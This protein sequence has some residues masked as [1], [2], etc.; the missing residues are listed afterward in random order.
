MQVP[1][2]TKD[3]VTRILIKPY[4]RKEY[5]SMEQYQYASIDVVLRLT[6]VITTL[7]VASTNHIFW[8]PKYDSCWLVI[9]IACSTTS[10]EQYR[11][12]SIDV[13]LR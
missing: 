12:A 11:Y 9:K 2:V 7:N 3:M 8:V 1:A 10:M 4:N 13:V 6:I 5:T